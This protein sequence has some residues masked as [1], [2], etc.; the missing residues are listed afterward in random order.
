MSVFHTIAVE[1]TLVAQGL[2][3]GPQEAQEA[4][5]AVGCFGAQ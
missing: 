4:R 3:G 5:R 1:H 2:V